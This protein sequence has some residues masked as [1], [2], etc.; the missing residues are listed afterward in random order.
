MP[1]PKPTAEQIAT[2]RA[3]I[4]AAFDGKVPWL[5]KLLH[6]AGYTRTGEPVAQSEL[7]ASIPG[8]TRATLL[9]WEEQGLT[10]TKK[11]NRKL[12]RLLDVAA[13]LHDRFVRPGPIREGADAGDLVYEQTRD[14][15]FRAD[16]RE[17]QLRI[18]RGEL[19]EKTD[20]E[21]VMIAMVLQVVAMH[22]GASAALA[23]Q[24]ANLPAT[25]CRRVLDNYLTWLDAEMSKGRVRV[26]SAARDA[27]RTLIDRLTD[28]ADPSTLA[29]PAARP[30]RR[31]KAT[32]KR[33]KAVRKRKTKA[34]EAS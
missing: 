22:R 19:I 9:H 21:R 8:L 17:L 23:P 31:R 28:G 2:M 25:D 30:K 11:S 20:A 15:R 18:K 27:V 3:S 34:T 7:V 33:K 24:L 4:Q 32:A 26:P 14:T 10:A 1:S 29:L 5:D 13:F 12:Y 6:D 16:L